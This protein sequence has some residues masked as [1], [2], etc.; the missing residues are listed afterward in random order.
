MSDLIGKVNRNARKKW[1]S[2]EMINKM[3]QREKLKNVNNEGRKNY[4]ILRNELK[5]AAHKAK[6]EYL[7]I[8]CDDIMEFQTA[9]RY[10]LTYMER[11][12][13]GWK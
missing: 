11:K 1:I 7:E 13:L 4:R 2:Q 3:G 6:K 9:G 10:D 12:E 5:R 8:V